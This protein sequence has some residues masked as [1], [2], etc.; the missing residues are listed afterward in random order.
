VAIA[1]ERLKH[2]RKSRRGDGSG[3]AFRRWQH[4]FA[5]ASLLNK[6]HTL[7]KKRGVEV[8]QV[9]PQDTSTIGMLKYVP[10]LSLSKDIAAAYVIGRRA[11]RF[12]EKLPKHYEA[13]LE[14][15]RFRENARAF[16]REKVKELKERRKREKNPSVKNRWSRE[17]RKA[18]RALL[19]VSP[20]GSP[21]SRKGSTDRRNPYGAN[22]W[23]VLRVGFFLPLLGREVP[24]DL[25]PLKS[26]LV[27]GLW[28]G[29]KAGLGPLLPVGG[30]SLRADAVND[31]A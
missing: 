28:E 24:R 12:E 2:L 26:I 23:R 5:Y 20:E 18:E 16:Y 7:A 31:F 6:I 27:Q 9:N 29:R 21:G 3:R 4:R 30:R 11:L 10:Q 19:L 15:H 17:F 14:D 1:T 8:V 25:S 22:P 13:L